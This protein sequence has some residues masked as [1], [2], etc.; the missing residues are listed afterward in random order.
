MGTTPPPP[1][2]TEDVLPDDVV[3]VVDGAA[4]TTGDDADCCEGCTVF[5]VVVDGVEMN[6]E[7]AIFPI[8][9]KDVPPTSLFALLLDIVPIAD[10][11]DD[12]AALKF[13]VV[14]TTPS[15]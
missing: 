13:V 10:D 2:R 5:D 11:A 14:E 6:G 15:I 12:C 4:A 7:S 8:S 1:L 3:V 9:N